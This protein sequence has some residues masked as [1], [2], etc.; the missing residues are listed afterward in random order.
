M[1]LPP[2]EAIDGALL[3]VLAET[4][5]A[6]PR[7]VYPRVT[8]RFPG[9]TPQDLA[10][11]RPDGRYLWQ[12][13]IQWARNRLAD[14][15]W[16]DRSE[17]R[18]WWALTEA[19]LREAERRANAA[20][21][22]PPAPAPLPDPEPSPSAEDDDSRPIVLAVVPGEA[23]RIAATLGEAARDS[24]HP[25][26]LERAV[27]EALAY[28]GFEVEVIGGP[29]KTDVLA[30]APLGAVGYRVVLD[31]K[32]T[33]SGAVADAQI[34]WVT[35][36]DHREQE[37]A[38]HACV[39]GPAFA[40]GRVRERAAEFD[41]S[42]LTASDLARIV[43]LH[44]DTPVALA[45]LRPLF[46][47]APLAGA[48]MLRVEAAAED[49]ARRRR[50]MLRLLEHIE[51]LSNFRPE[52][53]LSPEVLF[54]VVFDL[55][56]PDGREATPDD[57]R[58]ALSLLTAIGVLAPADGGGY[59]PQTSRR[60]ALRMLEAFGSAPDEQDNAADDARS[61]SRTDCA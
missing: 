41:T 14:R 49:R 44:A 22:T 48:A 40:E 6:R 26:R 24:A 18:G 1:A 9:I 29:G 57:I 58:G 38:D 2:R 13:E 5:R 27:G 53:V 19:G 23:E 54:G 30:V 20:A 32:S 15:G 61:A 17:Q 28:L 39:V 11:T 10:E 25:D 12:N 56:D 36:R 8:R 60:G 52:L 51:T 45:E 34:N 7:D 42:L 3:A 21:G 16:L 47:S 4:G 46:E 43:T 59:L 33:A 37:R 31:A 55:S 35:F 50:L